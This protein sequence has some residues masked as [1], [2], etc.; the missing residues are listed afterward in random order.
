MAYAKYANFCVSSSLGPFFGFCWQL[1]RLPRE[2]AQH[3]DFG[4]TSVTVC[5]L[6]GRVGG[7][8]HYFLSFFSISSTCQ[9]G[10]LDLEI[11]LSHISSNF[12]DVF[13]WTLHHFQRYTDSIPST[14]AKYR[15]IPTLPMVLP[16]VDN[17]NWI[18]VIN[19]RFLKNASV[20]IMCT[21]PGRQ[22]KNPTNIG[23]IKK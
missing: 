13:C 19:Q 4:D 22:T 14:V 10:H 1:G 16:C 7:G 3:G 12:C 20:F 23:N 11:L 9:V 17:Q 5:S 18:V 2:M 8:L 6:S 21:Q 15:I